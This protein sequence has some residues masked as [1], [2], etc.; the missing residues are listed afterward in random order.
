[1]AERADMLQLTRCIVLLLVVH[2]AMTATKD[3]VSIPG[4][5]EVGTCLVQEE[6]DA[7]IQSI[8]T[9]V[10]TTM[11]TIPNLAADLNWRMVSS[12]SPQY[13]QL[14]TAVSICLEGVRQ[15]HKWNQ[16]VQETRELIW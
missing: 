7:A 4:N 8:S 16:G 6:R 3:L 1:M 14:L 11:D 9:S 15:H 5:G 10:Q 12:S 13:E 2:S